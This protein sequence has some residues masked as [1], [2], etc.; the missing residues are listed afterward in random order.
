[1]TRY[2]NISLILLLLVSVV[3]A[4]ENAIAVD[5]ANK[6]YAKENYFNAIEL[7]QKVYKNGY[8]SAKLYFNIGNAYFK[9]NNF[10]SAILYYEKAKKL[11]PNDDNITYNIKIANTKIPDKIE[12]VPDIFFKRWWK[13]LSNI[14]SVDKWAI[15]TIIFFFVFFLLLGFYLILKSINLRKF[16]FWTASVFFVFTILSFML[17]SKQ[18]STIKNHNEAIVVSPNVTI[19]S[20]PNDNSIDLFV[21]HE[22]TKVQVLDTINDWS[23]ISIANGSRGWMK[24]TSFEKI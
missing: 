1:M 7:Y 18:Y 15:L 11:N 13:N 3:H 8:E 16:T 6:E 24:I 23:E 21:I 22:G 10:S 4:D 14:V 5:K 19:K 12:A 9:V 17:G 2:I 20:S